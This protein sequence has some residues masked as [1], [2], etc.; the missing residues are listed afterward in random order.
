[1]VDIQIQPRGVVNIQA[2]PHSVIS[3]PI[4]PGSAVNRSGAA[5]HRTAAPTHPQRIAQ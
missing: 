5:N 1:V 3:I 4:Q 2:E